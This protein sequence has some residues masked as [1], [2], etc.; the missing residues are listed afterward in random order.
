MQKEQGQ[1]WK[2]DLVA[3]DMGPTEKL[4]KPMGDLTF[5]D[6]YEAFAEAI[7]YEKST[8]QT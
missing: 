7:R 8:A 3:L 4:L 2:R 5:D 6:V 1:I